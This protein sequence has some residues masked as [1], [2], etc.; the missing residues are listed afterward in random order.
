MSEGWDP[1][2]PGSTNPDPCSDALGKPSKSQDQRE[3]QQDFASKCER[4]E[5]GNSLWVG[6]FVDLKGTAECSAELRGFTWLTSPGDGM[7]F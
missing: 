6:L 3:L 7:L 4:E 1:K 5:V 2:T